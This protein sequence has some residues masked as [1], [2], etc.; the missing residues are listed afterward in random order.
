[1]PM[2]VLT[3]ALKIKQPACRTELHTFQSALPN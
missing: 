2:A 1:V 3:A